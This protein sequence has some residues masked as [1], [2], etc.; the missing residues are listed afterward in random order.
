M[1]LSAGR[2]ALQGFIARGDAGEFFS[3]ELSA[4]GGLHQSAVPVGEGSIEPGAGGDLRAFGDQRRI[5]GL[6]DQG[7]V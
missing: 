1:A 6:S 7:P 2:L 4:V 3:G 5:L